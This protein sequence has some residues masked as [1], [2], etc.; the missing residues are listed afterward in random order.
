MND[1]P[2]RRLLPVATLFPLV[3]AWVCLKGQQAGFYNAEF[4]LAL[5]ALA[6][7]IVFATLIFVVSRSLNH[8]DMQ[9]SSAMQAL[10]A[11]HD[12][13]DQHVQE[14]T[15]ALAQANKAL[16]N[17]E[18]LFR[19][20]VNSVRDY[21]I[22]MLDTSGN[23]VS[24]NT[25][26]EHLKGYT[27]QE[28]LG[29]NFSRF[30]TPEDRAANIPQRLLQIAERE[31]HFVGEGWRV[32]KDGSRF[33][34][35]IVLTAIR[36]EQ[37]KLIGFS[38][39]ARNLTER[40]ERE[41]QLRFHASLQEAATDAVIATDMNFVIQSWNKAAEHMYGWREHEVLGK[42]ATEILDTRFPPELPRE[43]VLR[44]FH[45][46][47][48]WSGELTQHHKDGSAIAVLGS[49]VLLKDEHDTPVGIVSVN[50]DITSRKQA[51][52][53]LRLS[54]ERYRNLSS[55]LWD[56]A[57]SYHYLNGS[58]E[59]QLEWV[60]GAFEEITGH[61]IEEALKNFSLGTPIHPNDQGIFRQRQEKLHSGQDD[62]SEFRIINKRGEVRWLRSYGRPE[63]D[64]TRQA[65]TRVYIGVQDITERK[66]IEVELAE[67]RNR[68]R[69]LID[70]L[71]DFI[72]IK[73]MQHRFL[74]TNIAH[75]RA[76]GCASPDELIG[77]SDFDFFPHDMA[78]RFQD[79][80]TEIFRTGQPLLDYEQPSKGNAGGFVWA[81]SNKVPIRNVQGE[82]TGLVGITRDI[83]ERKQQAQ[84]L[85]IALKRAE[86][87]NRLK[88][89]FLATMSHELRTPLNAIIGFSDALSNHLAGELNERQQE[90][91]QIILNN[92][93]H[94]LSII[95]N[96]LDI[97]KIEAGQ[98]ELNNTAVN[99]A[100]L[101]DH[102]K[103]SLQ[104]LADIKGLSLLTMLDED[105][106]TSIMGDD[107][108]LK[109]II[110]NLV[111]NAI[112]F[113]QTGSVKVCIIKIDASNWAI[114]VTDTGIGIPPEALE[115]V[116]EQFRQVDNS[117]TRH[118][119]GTGLGLAIVRQLSLLMEGSAQVQSQLNKGS[120][121]TI[122]LPLT[123]A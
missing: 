95:N 101:L 15:L 49:T 12:Q 55:V 57:C 97:S 72:Y 109:Q 54:E 62:I 96:L 98:F 76:R 88:S 45:E 18:R 14:R 7:V 19:L 102:V 8:L 85:E 122:T 27:A 115:F 53:A 104:S 59:A 32:R 123:K 36:D 37:D 71:P 119:G 9:R 74:L 82:L 77:K 90:Y 63:W 6:N 33:W 113:T 31:G 91:M 39:V 34:A 117:S 116:F 73:D 69:T 21:A 41:R 114:K 30:Y 2:S 23:I 5:F 118:Y 46:N 105:M 16:E 17:S 111:G 43:Q 50:H 81:L 99:I 26:A 44:S 121:F 1:I 52:E 100:G 93:E 51:E 4:G 67:E 61:S 103:R 86:E 3:I 94:L 87:A 64:A 47:A 29:Q 79:E 60:V 42:L 92:G 89:E 112:K 28:I 13:L 70:T 38:K 84:A 107:L 58:Y 20:L 108:R 110:I 35:S 48:F 65:V 11:A 78:E 83:T 75:A 80:E 25:G 24:W 56:Y 106:P 40:M 10:Q 66:N 120:T 68:L 22:F